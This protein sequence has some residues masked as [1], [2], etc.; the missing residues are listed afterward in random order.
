MK[1]E[2][3]YLLN[4]LLI[5][6]VVFVIGYVSTNYLLKVSTTQFLEL[7][8]ESSKRE[9]QGFSNFISYQI[10]AGVEREVLIKNI[11]KSIE[12]SET[13]NGFICMF[14]WSG[15]EICH[16]DPKYI[17]QKVNSNEYFVKS[18]N[19]EIKTEDFYKL[20]KEKKQHGGIIDFEKNQSQIIYLYPVKNSDWI[21][22][23]R[24]NINKIEKA[25]KKLKRNFLI[26]YL[27]TSIGIIA[28]SIFTVRFIGNYYQRQLE[29]KNEKLTEEVI[30]LSKLNADL[31]V[32]KSKISD[33]IAIEESEEEEV[34][35]NE[36]NDTKITK[37]LL[38]YFKDQLIS[39]KV[40]DIAFI[41]TENSITFIVSLDGKR[42][43][44][45]SSLDD[46]Y[47]RL[48]HSLFFRANRQYILS[49]KGINEIL[50]YGNNQL[51]ITTYSGDD[52]IVSKNKASEFK[53]WLEM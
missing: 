7:Q 40:E 37:R 5:S 53:K 20:L 42:Y 13:E 15:V 30:N 3:T 31:A 45:N 44:T 2:T 52:V 21:V 4:F 19:S 41:N 43:T 18:I 47:S 9:A 34:T 1:K 17:G 12:G 32:Y 27:I 35:S 26:V 10:E 23:A 25:V 24:A 48:D 51:K 36:S 22:A 11:Q 14:D 6:T 28:L 39:I 46:L 8:I 33:K 50:K 49:V 16:P 29:I 38:T